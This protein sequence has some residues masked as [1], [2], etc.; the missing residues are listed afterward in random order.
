M[1]TSCNIQQLS[2]GQWKGHREPKENHWLVEGVEAEEPV[3]IESN[4]EW[5]HVRW[6]HSQGV[7]THQKSWKWDF[8]MGMV[9]LA[10][11]ECLAFEK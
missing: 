5:G 6:R 3:G 2:S 1:N 7:L 8:D 11:H 9:S 4:G 10:L